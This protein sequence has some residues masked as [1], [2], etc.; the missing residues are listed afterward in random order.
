MQ[1][2][3]FREV[4]DSY[5]SDELLVETNHDVIAHLEACGECRRE[6]A[7]RRE[8]RATLR[9]SFTNADE[10]QIRDQ[11]AERLQG[12]LRDI[13][14]Y[15]ATS[16]LSRRAWMVIAACLLVAAAFALIAAWQRAQA[17]AQIASGELRDP[18]VEQ[19]KTSDTQPRPAATAV[20]ADMVLAKMSEV[21]AGDH[22]DCAI[23]HRLPDRPID[24]EDAGHKY[25][26]AYLDL[27]QAVMS[28]RAEFRDEIELV[29]GHACLFQGRWFGHVVV[30][31]RGR[32]V[33]LLVTKLEDPDRIAAAREELPKD[34]A[35][36]VIA[37]STAGGYRISCFRTSQHTVFVVSDLQEAEN[38]ALARELA[39]SVYE[40]I[41]R[42]EDIT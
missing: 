19:V 20:D 5:L 25:D 36:Q 13:A 21:A 35:A 41:T 34:A 9:A 12:D 18:N 8:L 1:C 32:L 22:R 42:A 23:G 29:T 38:L 4:A 11:F 14:T 10:L 17:P 3:D 7:A 2:R 39:P 27:V 31:H 26:R 15:E 37:C 28:V 24:L 30:R 16:L 40:H 6:L 33:S